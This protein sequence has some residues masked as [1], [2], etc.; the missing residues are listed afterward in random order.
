VISIRS[1]P[2]PLRF[3]L[4]GI[5]QRE[6]LVFIRIFSR[7]GCG[8]FLV[9]GRAGKCASGS[10]S[11]TRTPFL[12]ETTLVFLFSTSRIS[13]R[14][15]QRQKRVEGELLRA[16]SHLCFVFGSVSVRGK[17]EAVSRERKVF[18]P[19]KI[20]FVMVNCVQCLYLSL[21]LFSLCVLCVINS[22]S[23]HS[24]APASPS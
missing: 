8:R 9:R 10:H 12:R 14:I 6:L 16:G 1:R 11:T 22:S 18:I 20:C 3:R 7:R 23:L 21:C 5:L 24:L 15:Q 17:S 19:I 4:D 13:I 2:H